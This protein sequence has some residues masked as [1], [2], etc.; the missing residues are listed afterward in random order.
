LR[1][2]GIPEQGTDRLRQAADH[3][4]GRS[5]SVPSAKLRHADVVAMGFPAPG[6]RATPMPSLGTDTRSIPASKSHVLSVAGKDGRSDRRAPR[7]F[8]QGGIRHPQRRR[9]VGQPFRIAGAAQKIG[10]ALDRGEARHRRSRVRR[11]R[12][13]VWLPSASGS[14]PLGMTNWSGCPMPSPSAGR[15]RRQ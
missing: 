12:V 5:S 4:A 13:S 2:T 8:F 7:L 6:A 15:P 1:L 14:L 3:P 11:R 9:A 10:V